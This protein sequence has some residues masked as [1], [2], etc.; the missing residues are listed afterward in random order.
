MTTA[1][2]DAYR[3]RLLALRKRLDRDESQLRE[4]ALRGVGGEASGSLSD[5][6]HHLADLSSR[7]FEEDVTLSLLE[8]E[9]QIVREIDGAWARIDTGTF[10]RCE[11][12]REEI[13]RE[14]LRALPYARY[15][16]RCAHR[17]RARAPRPSGI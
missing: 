16:V 12:C 8:N 5:V 11:E 3:Q 14:R 2:I 9:E 15:C 7:Q 6:P 10:G 1:E 17:L 4:E 13:S